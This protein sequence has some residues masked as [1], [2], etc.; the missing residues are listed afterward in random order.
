MCT[1]STCFADPF[2]VAV[3]FA[4]QLLLTAQFQESLP[5]FY[6]LPLLGKFPIYTVIQYV[7]VDGVISYQ[8]SALGRYSVSNN[9][10]D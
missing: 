5:I 4:L 7:L 3:E 6:A 10:A 1:K 9:R 8:Q 2:N